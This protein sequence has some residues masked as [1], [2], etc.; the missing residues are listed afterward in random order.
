MGAYLGMGNLLPVEPFRCLWKIEIDRLSLSKQ[1]NRKREG[2]EEGGDLFS[3]ST[4]NIVPPLFVY[5]GRAIL[6]GVNND[7]K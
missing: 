4:G 7:T 2:G 1:I 3:N 5:G 6:S